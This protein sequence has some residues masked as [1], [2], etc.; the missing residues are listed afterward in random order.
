MMPTCMQWMNR[1]GEEEWQRKMEPSVG[2]VSSAGDEL[3]DKCGVCITPISNNEKKES[4]RDWQEQQQRQQ[5]QQQLMW[6]CPGP[7]A[8]STQP[9]V[10]DYFLFSFYN[11]HVIV[12]SIAA[13]RPP[14]QRLASWAANVGQLDRNVVVLESGECCRMQWAD[15]MLAGGYHPQG[16]QCAAARRG[17]LVE[18][19]QALQRGMGR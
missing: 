9:C 19:I 7:Q 5:Q 2:V 14:E 12:Y 15:Y 1:G 13:I 6:D 10:G 11:K 4:F 17:G 16:T 3:N 18:A 8:K